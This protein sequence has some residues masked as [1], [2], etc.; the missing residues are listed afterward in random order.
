MK[1]HSGT[2]RASR[3]LLWKLRLRA[4]A[5]ALGAVAFGSA[6]FFVRQAFKDGVWRFDFYL[7]NKSLAAAS[8]FLIALSMLLTSVHF[9]SRRPR[10]TLA[11]RKHLGLAGFWTGAAHGLASHFFL[12]EKFPLFSWMAGHPAEAGLGLAALAL[13][14]GMAVLSLSSVKGKL[15]GER[16]RRLLR[17]AGYAALVLA[18]VH[19]GALK[20]TSW[21]KYFRTFSS[22]LPSFSL[23]VVLF[24]A[25][26]LILRL[27]V[28][29]FGRRRKARTPS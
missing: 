28:L 21:T 16:W 27:T 15:G 2:K 22:V 24:A 11:Y 17:W 23:P 14:G 4:A 1:R 19:A 13:F 25:A 7:F 20:W 6:Y 9:L 8:L 12:P 29:V 10:R 3:L 18:A 26:T 5:A